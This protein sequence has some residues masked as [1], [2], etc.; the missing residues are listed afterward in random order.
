MADMAAMGVLDEYFS[1]PLSYEQ[2]VMSEHEG[3]ILGIR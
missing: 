2:R 1:P 3:W